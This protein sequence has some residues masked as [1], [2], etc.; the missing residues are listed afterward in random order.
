MYCMRCGRETEEGCAFCEACLA[1]MEKFPVEPDTVVTLPHRRVDPPIRRNLHRKG[2]T[3]EEQI[4]L[5]TRRTRHLAVALLAALVLC[6]AMA[7]LLLWS[8]P[9]TDYG[10]GQNYRSAPSSTAPTVTMPASETAEPT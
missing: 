6:A 10:M 2:P 7:F 3:P 4:A 1:E 8:F 9:Q 5:L